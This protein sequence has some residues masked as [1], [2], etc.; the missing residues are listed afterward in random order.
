V[1]HPLFA[2]ESIAANRRGRLTTEQVHDPR[3]EV[4]PRNGAGGDTEA[5]L[6]AQ[7]PAADLALAPTR[8]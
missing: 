3:P 4:D 5:Q 8:E 6:N 2:V 1:T 7:G